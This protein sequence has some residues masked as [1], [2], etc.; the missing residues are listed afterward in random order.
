[1]QSSLLMRNPDEILQHIVGD[2]VL[3]GLTQRKGIDVEK[4]SLL[5]LST[6]S[7]RMRKICLP[8]LFHTLYLWGDVKRIQAMVGELVRKPHLTDLVR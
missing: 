5:A 7:S 8:P 2:L 3:D 6:V 1:M 4:E